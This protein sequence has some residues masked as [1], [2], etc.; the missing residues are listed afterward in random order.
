MEKVSFIW[1]WG[2]D[3]FVIILFI[4]KHLGDESEGS[5]SLPAGPQRGRVPRS[6]EG[7][8]DQRLS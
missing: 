2:L 3:A 4:E 6:G 7:K 8:L 1:G 5:F